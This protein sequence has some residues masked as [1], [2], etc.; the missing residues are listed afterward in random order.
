[1]ADASL[2]SPSGL[3][4]VLC[5]RAH[6][7]KRPASLRG[8]T[9]QSQKIAAAIAA[10]V[11]AGGMTE[12]V[13]TTLRPVERRYRLLNRMRAMGYRDCELPSARAF[14]RHFNGL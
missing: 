6:A 3:N 4:S 1:M 5:T 8:A 14:A 9:Y 13:L 10:E 12:A 2:S 11:A 7:R